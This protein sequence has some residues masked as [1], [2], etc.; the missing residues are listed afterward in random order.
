MAK[1]ERQAGE[2]LIRVFDHV[3]KK[4]AASIMWAPLDIELQWN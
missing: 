4:V 3:G 1:Q 2:G